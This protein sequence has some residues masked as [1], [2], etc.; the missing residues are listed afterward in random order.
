MIE[1][2]KHK[3]VTQLRGLVVVPTRE[4]VQ[5][6]REVIEF[7]AAGT[8]LGVGSAVGSKSKSEERAILVKRSQVWDELGCIQ[9]TQQFGERLALEYDKHSLLLPQD[10]D[11]M[12]GTCTGISFS[13]RHTYLYARQTG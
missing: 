10:N 11:L 13:R 1:D 5:Q 3:A 9:L 8:S 7:C 12:P 2:L 4:L 6:V